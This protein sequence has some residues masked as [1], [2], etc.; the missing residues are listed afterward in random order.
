MIR[1]KQTKRNVPQELALELFSSDAYLT[2]NKK[3]LKTFGPEKAIFISNL[4]DKF[5]YFQKRYP[6]AI[7]DGWFYRS[8]K[9]QI[10]ET[11]LTNY[12][13]QKCK[14]ELQIDGV[15]SIK[16]QG[17]PA[18]EWM[19]IHFDIVL[20]LTNSLVQE[21][22]DS[23]GHN[24]K[25]LINNKNI[26]NKIPINE[27]SDKHFQY[28]PLAE[29]LSTIIQ[30][31]KHIHHTPSQVS[32]WAR[33]IYHLITQHQVSEKRITKA[34]DW[35]ADHIGEKYVPVIESG[36]SLRE[37]FIKL[38]AAIERDGEGQVPEE[39]ESA[40]DLIDKYFGAQA[41]MWWKYCFQPLLDIVSD[42]VFAEQQHRLARKLTV[43]NS[44]YISKQQIPDLLGRENEEIWGRWQAIPGA[45]GVVEKFIQWLGEQNWIGEIYPAHLHPEGAVFQQFLGQYQ[46]EIGLN[47]FDGSSIN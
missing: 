7:I 45:F 14:K 43:I 27:K 40:R 44:W 25:E 26:N 4:I 28:L 19:K 3:L 35:Y 41:N 46:K 30:S 34:L 42:K 37:K 23:L 21:F 5:K 39:S 2:L 9:D 38:E 16:K 32:S 17:I 20:E 47:F 33:E 24:N 8:H 12:A 29:Q 18:K 13:I 22:K 10:N 15:I 11:G 36:R 31:N 1:T 6:H